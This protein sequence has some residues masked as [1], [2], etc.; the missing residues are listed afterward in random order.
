MSGVILGAAVAVAGAAAS[1]YNSN[2]QA[3]TQKQAMQQQ[4]Q[5]AKAADEKSRQAERRQNAQQADI[6]G[7][8]SENQNSL[9]SGGSTL[10][11]GA[12]GVDPTKLNLG[13]GNQL[14]G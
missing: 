7:I 5:M 9:L 12:G 11:T 8:L 3:R 4:E 13:K 10:L 1:V 6:S 2:K 14:G